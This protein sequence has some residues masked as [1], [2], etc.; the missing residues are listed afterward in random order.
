LVLALWLAK[1][2]VKLRIIDKTAEPGTTS[3]ALAV[4]ARTLE[5]YRQ[6]DLTDFV[7]EH[8]HKV[9]AVRL[10]VK[11]EPQTRVSFEEIGSDLTPYAFLQIFPQDEHERLLTASLEKLGTSVERRTELL[12]YRDEGSRVVAHL[13]RPDGQEETCEAAYIAGCDGVH[14]IVRETMGTGYP[15]GTYRQ[16]FY[17][18]DVQASG[19]AL[20]G[21]LHVDLEEADFL[22]VFP[23]SGKGRAR[24][25][26]TVRDER[27][28]HAETLRFED[29][30]RRIIDNL[31]VKVEAVNW[32]STYHVHHR[33]TEHFRKGCAFLLGETPFVNFCSEQCLRSRSTIAIPR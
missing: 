1:M 19:P 28:Q 14:S 6:L 15:G 5:L 2:G 11:G 27:A 3:R 10:W 13:R 9:P 18:A 22:A 29:V 16:L 25:I 32:F 4:H 8:A 12:G 23:L 30:S 31:K 20:D 24:L 17:V 21:E 33:V 7:L 26:G